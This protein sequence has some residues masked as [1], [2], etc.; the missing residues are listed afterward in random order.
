M[1]WVRSQSPQ[2]NADDEAAAAFD[3]LKGN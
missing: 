3:E 1:R 2:H